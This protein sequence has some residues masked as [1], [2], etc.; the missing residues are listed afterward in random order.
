M[1]NGVRAYALGN[2]IVRRW[3]IGFPK[4]F[5]FGLS[6]ISVILGIGRKQTFGN[7]TVIDYLI[8]HVLISQNLKSS[9][10]TKA[11]QADNKT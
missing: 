2:F 6:C 5:M 8:E 9:M 4:E 7:E 3:V 11:I 10:H 1:K